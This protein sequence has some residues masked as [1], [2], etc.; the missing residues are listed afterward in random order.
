VKEAVCVG[1]FFG[2][3]FDVLALVHLD[4]GEREA[5]IGV[6]ELVGLAVAEE[7]FVI[8]PRLLDVVNGE[9][10]VGDSGDLRP[11]R[12]AGLRRCETGQNEGQCE[13]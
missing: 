2:E 9:S 13:E 10:D 8:D 3:E 4:K 6:V 5:A 11:L 12:G 7:V 1:G